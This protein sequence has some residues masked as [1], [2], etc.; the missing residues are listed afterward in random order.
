MVHS[1]K[2]LVENQLG[3]KIKILR[4]DN[5]TEYQ[6]NEFND[7]YREVG[8]KRET[9]TIYTPD[10]NGVSE[11]KNLTII[12]AT[13]AMLHDQGLPKF[14][15]GE[16]ANTIVYVQNRCPHQALDFKT[17]EEVFIGLMY[18]IDQPL[19]EP[20]TSRKRP[21]W[22][23]DTLEDVEKHIAPRGTFR[24]SKESNRYQRYLA[25]MSMIVQSESCTFEE[26]V[27]HQVWK[28]AMNKEYDSIMKND[29]WDVVPRP[30]DK[31]VV[32]SKWFYKIKHGAD[33]SAEKFKARF[34]ARGFSPKEG[35]DYDEIFAPISQY[36]TIHSIISLAASQGWSLHQIDVKTSLLH[37]LLKEEVYIEQP[38]GFEV[39]DR[40]S[41]VCRLKKS[42]HWLK[43]ALRVW[44]ER[45]DRYIM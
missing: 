13:H 20:S 11:R 7:Y 30:K 29:V 16:Y 34:V 22:S 38:E 4:A 32:T 28:D 25:A 23:K 35:V 39:Q 31:S 27:K 19:N 37:G 41:H 42:F 10:Q 36:T 21:L 8:I 43:Q 6:S 14:L 9:T 24:E 17:L 33:G 2:T 45:I 26:V 12:E 15:W 5:G 40:K 1:F 3:K 18:T 44:Y